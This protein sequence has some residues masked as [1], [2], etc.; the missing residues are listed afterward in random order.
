MVLNDAPAPN[1][2]NESRPLL[3]DSAQ[4]PPTDPLANPALTGPGVWESLREALLGRPRALACVQIG[5]TSLCP[6]RCVYCPHTTRADAWPGRHMRAETFAAL[7]PLLRQAGRAHLQGWGEPFLHPRF[8][9]FARLA[10]RAGCRVSTTTCGLRMDDDLARQIVDSGIDVVA[11]SL[12]G[13]DEASNAPRAGVPFARV[14]EAIPHLQ[15]VR[16][17]RNAVHLEV[18]LAY[19]LLPSQLDAVRRLPELMRD[20]GVHAAV[21]STLDYIPGPDLAAEAFPPPVTPE[22]REQ[23]E[24]ARSSLREVASRAAHFG[25][26]VHY[27]LPSTRPRPGG[28]REEAARTLYVGVDGDLAPCVYAC[29]PGTTEPERL[30]FGSVEREQPLAVWNGPAWTGFRAALASDTPPVRCRTCPKR[31]EQG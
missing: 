15:T 31:L 8:M 9:D 22:A 24:A 28:C 5:V 11:F 27:A 6:G 1:S 26:D 23:I 21:I 29:V 7:W 17:A 20:L 30:V 2:G 10:L 4:N 16:R 19:L 13:T 14:T 3:P 12:V 18:H 25:A